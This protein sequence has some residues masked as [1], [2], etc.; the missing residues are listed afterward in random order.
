MSDDDS[1]D[2]SKESKDDAK[3]AVGV[4]QS[5]WGVGIRVSGLGFTCTLLTRVSALCASE[6]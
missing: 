5:T 1:S 2:D 3:A 6:G 4:I